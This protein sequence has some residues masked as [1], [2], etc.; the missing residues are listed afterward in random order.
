MLAAACGGEAAPPTT[1]PSAAPATTVLETT[2]APTTAPPT[3]QTTQAP[4]TTEAPAGAAEFA[5]TSVGL[6]PAGP[7]AVITNIGSSPG[8]LGG[9]WL[10]QRPS[11]YQIPEIELQPGEFTVISFGGTDFQPPDGA[12][13]TFLAN[14]GGVGADEG[15]IA[16]YTSQSFGNSN[17]I[18]DYVEWGSADHGR[19]SVAVLAGIWP[20]GGF[21]ST[22]DATV[23]L[24]AQALPTTGPDDWSAES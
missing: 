19:S 2:T 21:V 7:M 4:T 8:V 5:I 17:A 3:T 1:Q 16:L 22:S 11:Y 18:V 9:Y 12:K 6:N 23:S 20:E 13:E 10:C 14:L 15:E 24:L